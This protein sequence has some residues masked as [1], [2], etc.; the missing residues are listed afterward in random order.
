MCP[1]GSVVAATSEKNAVVTNGMS[2]YSRNGKNS[3]SAILVT[4]GKDDLQS[5]HPLAGIDFQRKIESQAYIMGG[6]GYKAPVQRLEDFLSK[7]NSVMFG[8]VTPT[9]TPGTSFAEADSYLPEYVSGSIRQAIS[10]MEDWMP[11]FAFQDALLTGP[12]TRSSSP[13]RI[14]RGSNHQATGISGLF[15][16]GEGAGYSGGIIS[17]AV[18]GVICAEM[19]LAEQQEARC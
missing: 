16:C 12:E 9:Y 8:E 19:I 2:E 7:Q 5:A 6:G 15:P 17:A 14:L 4:I 11:G 18:D 1:G 10:E 13:V 3:N